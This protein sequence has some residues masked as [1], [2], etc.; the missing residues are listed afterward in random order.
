MSFH[1]KGWPAAEE[2]PYSSDE[3]DALVG[4]VLRD[5]VG[6]EEPSPEVWHRIKAG[7]ER[8]GRGSPSVRGLSVQWSWLVQVLVLG[9]VILVAFGLSLS[10]GFDFS[11]DHEYVVNG[12][13]TPQ[14]DSEE[15]VSPSTDDMLSRY[16]FFQA[17][18]EMT[19]F[20]H[21]LLP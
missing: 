3:M 16:Y 10:Q 15:V 13:L 8:R 21:R 19:T 9:L 4:W 12:E 14:P 20:D 17:A 1:R 11:L 18:R 7:L 6:S 2:G 5:W